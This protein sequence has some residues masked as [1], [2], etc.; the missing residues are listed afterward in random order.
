MDLLSSGKL[1][2][3]YCHFFPFTGKMAEHELVDYSSDHLEEVV[4][5]VGIG[6]S[7]L[8][9]VEAL[10]PLWVESYPAV[11][12]SPAH[13]EEGLSLYELLL[14]SPSPFSDSGGNSIFSR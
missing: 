4:F 14:S 6:V 2:F 12:F 11:M 5:W 7:I 9:E 13:G 8:D 3:F 1:V 10:P